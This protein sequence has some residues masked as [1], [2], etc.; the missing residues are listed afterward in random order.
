MRL[1]LAMLLMFSGYSF[2][3]CGNIDDHDQRAY[4]NST[5]GGSSCGNIDN[6]DLR[7]RCEAMKR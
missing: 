1:L 7:T 5:K 3:S 4:C 2:A 6:H